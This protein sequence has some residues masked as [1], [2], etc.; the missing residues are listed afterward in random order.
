MIWIAI[1][2]TSIGKFGVVI[3]RYVRTRTDDLQGINSH[4]S[5][6]REH[7]QFGTRYLPRSA[8]PEDLRQCI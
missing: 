2:H 1:K 4:P 3:L 6:V 8:E 7:D 5:A